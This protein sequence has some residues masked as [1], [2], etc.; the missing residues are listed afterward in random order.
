MGVKMN[1]NFY[2][3]WGSISWGKLGLSLYTMNMTLIIFSLTHRIEAVIEKERL[4][5][6]MM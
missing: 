2:Y 4:H 6:K 1:K 5:M 3:L